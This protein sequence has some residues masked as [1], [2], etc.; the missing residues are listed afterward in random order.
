MSDAI[1]RAEQAA[2]LLNDDLLKE[3]LQTLKTQTQALFFELPSNDTPALER[4]HMMDK[5]RQQFENILT[6]IIANGEVARHGLMAEAHAKAVADS[7]KERVR[8]R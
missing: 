8:Q 6:A 5:M 7:I 3:A 1:H 4:L 2:R